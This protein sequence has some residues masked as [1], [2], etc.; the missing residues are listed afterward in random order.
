MHIPI[1]NRNIRM[2]GKHVV[3]TG[4]RLLNI[5]SDNVIQEPIPKYVGGALLLS[6]EVAGV[7][8]GV[9]NNQRVITKKDI[10]NMNKIGSGF[11]SLQIK[12]IKKN[13]NNLKFV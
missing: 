11:S 3:K 9:V 2:N 12:P 8:G 10:I 6:K 4:G 5:K 13:R 1:Q 7:V